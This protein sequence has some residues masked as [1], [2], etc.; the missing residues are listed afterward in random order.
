VVAG[1]LDLVEMKL[2][3]EKQMKIKAYINESHH[4]ST[5]ED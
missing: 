5:D 4:F 1:K 3:K 2:E